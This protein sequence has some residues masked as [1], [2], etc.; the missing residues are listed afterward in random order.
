MLNVGPSARQTRVSGARPD[1]RPRCVALWVLSICFVLGS[2]GSYAAD[3]EVSCPATLPPLSGHLPGLPAEWDVVT[4]V[5]PLDL[6]GP[7]IG[8]VRG[9]DDRANHEERLPNGDILKTWSFDRV[10]FVPYVHCLYF[11]TKVLLVQKIPPD[12]KSCQSLWRADPKLAK[13]EEITCSR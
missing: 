6:A 8:D 12:I 5:L 7:L 2:G 11:Y 9:D 4:S 10:T 3:F 13:L 1:G